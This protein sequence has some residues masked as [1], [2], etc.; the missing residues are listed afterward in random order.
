MIF[1]KDCNILLREGHKHEKLT[2]YIDR[3]WIENL[4]L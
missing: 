3:S 4:I 1:I 2:R